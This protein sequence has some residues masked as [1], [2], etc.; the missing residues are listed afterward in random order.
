M[1]NVIKVTDQDE[2]FELLEDGELVKESRWKFGTNQ[3]FVVT[4]PPQ[5]TDKYM[6]T[7]QCHFD[8]GIQTPPPYTLV[9]VK[10]E[11]RQITVWVP[12]VIEN[13]DASEKNI[14]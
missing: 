11:Q 12:D 7:V 13:E 6:I 10:P 8:E 2:F 5:G 9:R 1:S 4:Y 3:T 14:S